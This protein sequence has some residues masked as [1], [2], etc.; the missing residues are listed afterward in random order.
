MQQYSSAEADMEPVHVYLPF[1]QI[2]LVTIGT[3][4]VGI[5]MLEGFLSLIQIDIK[6]TAY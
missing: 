4:I 5:C 6:K 1:S 3:N 2:N